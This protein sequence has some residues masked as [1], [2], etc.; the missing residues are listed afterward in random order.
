LATVEIQTPDGVV[1][2]RLERDHLTI[3]RLATNDIALPYPH[4]S[5]QHAELRLMG[6][7]WWVVD[8]RST[9]GLHVAGQRVSESRLAPGAPVL[10]SPFITLSLME[11]SAPPSYPQQYGPPSQ[12]PSYPQQARSYPQQYGGPP[13]QAPVPTPPAPLRE[14]VTPLSALGPRSPYADDE[15]PFYP[16]MRPVGPARGGQPGYAPAGYAPAGYAPAAPATLT[17]RPAPYAPG[18]A[19]RPGEMNSSALDPQRQ[20]A[21]LFEQRRTAGVAPSSLLH[22]CQTCGQRTMP[23]A[24]Y[25]QN[26][27]HS[28]ASECARCRLSLLP[29]Q[30]LC[31]RCQTPNPFSVRR[32]RRTPGPS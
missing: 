14:P 19:V 23:D 13:S 30:D 20:A 26:C 3:G 16:Q 28:I 8:L 12:A 27:H 11:L 17:A 18:S 21:H 25:C 32:S 15:A 7:T 6:Q 29:I 5:R 31:P 10:L 9:N 24:V 2:V 22:V 1:R 4:I